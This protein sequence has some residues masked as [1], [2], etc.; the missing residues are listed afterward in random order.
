VSIP[1]RRARQREQRQGTRRQILAAAD[2]FLREHP[3]RELS[4]EVVMAETGL[5]RTAFY[6]HFDD[7]TELVLRLLDELGEELYP[8]AERWGAEAG[9]A[10]PTAAVEGLQ[11]VV[12]FFARNGALIRAIV[13]AA[14]TDEQIEHAYR[15]ALEGFVAIT[16]T[17]LDRLVQLGRLE[18]P[19]TRALARALNLMNEA[20]LLDEFGGGA[21]DRTVA[22]ETLTT[23]WL[24]ALGPGRSA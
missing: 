17:T 15:A 11:D 3:F 12:D 6:R 22:L 8:I 20:Y 13:E 23:I 1:A 5:T 16:T 9:S 10:Y 7:V 14:V 18:V 19:D 24:R 21:G 4:V 2:R